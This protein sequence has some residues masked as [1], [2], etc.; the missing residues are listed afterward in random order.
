MPLYNVLQVLGLSI[1]FAFAWWCVGVAVCAG[2]DQTL[3]LTGHNSVNKIAT[4]QTAIW[5]WPVFLVMWLVLVA[6]FT[7][8][9]L[10]ALFFTKDDE[11]W[12]EDDELVEE[13]EKLG[14]I[15]NIQLFDK[16]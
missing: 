1:V 4:H 7:A 13:E 16:P 15:A 3:T 2:L 10:A 6:V 12:V 14:P 9:S 8:A 11:H 5:A